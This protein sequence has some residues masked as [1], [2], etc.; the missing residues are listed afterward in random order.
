MNLNFTDKDEK[1][2]VKIILFLKT[3]IIDYI[4][5]I[6]FSKLIIKLSL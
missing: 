3:K 1:F 4:N 2:R 6:F 5:R